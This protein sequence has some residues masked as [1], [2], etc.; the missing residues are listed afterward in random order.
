[1]PAAA[2]SL[3]LSLRYTLAL[4]RRDGRLLSRGLRRG[5]DFHRPE[6]SLLFHGDPRPKNAFFH[7][8]PGD[9]SARKSDMLWRHMPGIYQRMEAEALAHFD[10]IWCVRESGVAT[11]RE[12]LSGCAR[13]ASSFIPTWVDTDVFQPRG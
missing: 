4:R 7:Q 3:P 8:D 10:R 11:L 12:R 9:V 1:M 6:P 13:G 5:F 2:A